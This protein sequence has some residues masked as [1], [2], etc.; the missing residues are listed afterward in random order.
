[1]NKKDSRKFSWFTLGDS[2]YKLLI[3]MVFYAG[4]VVVLGYSYVFI[5]IVSMTFPVTTYN[6]PGMY[7]RGS[8]T[9]LSIIAGIIFF[10]V[11]SIV[12]KLVCE[13]IL[14]I[15]DVLKIYTSSKNRLEGIP[16]NNIE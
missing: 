12:W 8:N 15:F 7:T 1:M 10:F 2:S 4:L 9:Y 11:V 14:L 3:T 16:N 5:Q 6:D 13:F